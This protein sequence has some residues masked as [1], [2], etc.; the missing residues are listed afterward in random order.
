MLAPSL[1]VD[2]NV[3]QEGSNRGWGFL[4]RFPHAKNIYPVDEEGKTLYLK[5]PATLP[6]EEG[7]TRKSL[8]WWGVQRS[9]FPP[10]RE[11]ESSEDESK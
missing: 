4:Q 3:V 5:E 8:R 11:N 2:L 9:K 10:L 6:G 1:H 7:F